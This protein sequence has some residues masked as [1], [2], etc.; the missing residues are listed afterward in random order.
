VIG[1]TT[2]QFLYDGLNPVQELDGASTPHVTANLLTGLGIDERF[3][4][5]DSSGTANFLTDLSGSTIALADASGNVDTNYTY[6][7]FGNVAAGG[8]ASAS[9]YQFTGRE[10]DGTG[11]Y[12]YRARYYSPVLQRFIGQDPIDFAGGDANLYDYANADPI[13]SADPSGLQAVPAPVP[14][15]P[16]FVFPGTPANQQF[17]S[18]TL[19]LIHRLGDAISKVCQNA[20][21]TAGC[22]ER[23]FQER[24]FCSRYYGSKLYGLCIARAQ[25]RLRTCLDGRDDPGP[26]DPLDPD[27]SND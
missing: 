22:M 10:D 3:T 4:R 11:L 18:G 26:L 1:G 8:S 24:N 6:A 13:N 9:S 7:P 14:V 19:D 27:W 12:F 20:K 15:F 23:Y 2:T 5:T 16:P 21:S 17:T 25:A